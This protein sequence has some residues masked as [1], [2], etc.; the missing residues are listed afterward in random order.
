MTPGAVVYRETE[1]ALKKLRKNA[2]GKE[3]GTLPLSDADVGEI[4]GIAR[5]HR[6]R[7]DHLHHV[8]RGESE[9]KFEHARGLYLSAFTTRVC[10]TVRTFAKKRRRATLGEIEEFANAI[11]V[12]EPLSEAVTAELQPK[13]K[14][15]FRTI[16]KC[17]PRRM[18]QQFIVRDVLTAVGIDNEFDYAHRGAGGEKAMIRD[19]CQLIEQGYSDWQEVDIKQCFASLE[20][21]H[22]G[23]LPLPKELIRHVVFLPRCA[24]IKVALRAGRGKS[25]TPTS[26]TLGAV[27]TLTVEMITAAT[28]EA[29]RGLP[30]GSV[31]S[32]LVARAFVGRELRA[33][34][35]KTEVVASCWVDNLTLGARSRPELEQAFEALRGRLL[36]HPA[37]PIHL[38]VDPPTSTKQGKVKVFGYV[39]KPGCGYGDNFVHVQPGRDRFKRFHRKCYDRWKAEGQPDGVEALENF[40]H[41]RLAYWMPSQQAWTVVPFWSWHSALNSAFIYVCERDGAESKKTKAPEG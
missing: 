32:P 8:W 22:L 37:G 4:L 28:M 21:A 34:L 17:G 16:T 36:G 38:H 9:A 25:P 6:Q 30:Q 7:T 23:W 3:S 20:P 39:L 19:V 31:L 40:I 41:G 24:R 12:W 26:A 27:P 33:V 18:T 11:D 10:A 14:G 29:R 35:G 15:G 13:P 2:G 5:R 1:E